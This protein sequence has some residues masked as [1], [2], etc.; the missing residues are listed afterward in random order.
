MAKTAR[1]VWKSTRGDC[2]SPSLAGELVD[3]I[4]TLHTLIE[5]PY[6]P[7]RHYMRG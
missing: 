1:T 4:R 3:L 7:E 2:R 5:D 6:R